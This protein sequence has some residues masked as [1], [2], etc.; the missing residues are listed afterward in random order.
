MDRIF[1]EFGFGRGWIQPRTS[2]DLTGRSIGRLGAGFENWAPPIEVFQRGNELVVRADLPG[3]RKDDISVDVTDEGITISGERKQEHEEERGGVYRSERSYGS[4]CRIVPLP[5]G[6]IADQAKA[7]FK[8][9][10]LEVVMP[11]PPD[12]V[13]RGRRLE[14]GGAPESKK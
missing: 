4:F 5:Q 14:I 2:R 12:Q 1:D 9:G 10:V 8:D 3:M 13:T 7:S 6:A 11:A